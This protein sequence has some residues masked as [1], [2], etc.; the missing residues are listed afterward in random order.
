MEVPHLAIAGCK[1]YKH[2]DNYFE[3]NLDGTDACVRWEAFKAYMTGEIISYT[4]PRQNNSM[5]KWKQL[6]TKID[7]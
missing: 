7:C 3:I 5:W 6:K 2:I 1:V 4:N